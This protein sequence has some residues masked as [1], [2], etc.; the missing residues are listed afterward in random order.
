MLLK[1]LKLR[2]FLSQCAFDAITRALFLSEEEDALVQLLCDDLEF[3]EVR[4]KFLQGEYCDVDED[5]DDN[6]T[7]NQK[8]AARE[9][10][11]TSK[12][13]QL[14][15]LSA[16]I[17][18][19]QLIEKFPS[20]KSHLAKDA[21]IVH[22]QHFEN[23]AVK[24]QTGQEDRLLRAEKRAVE[25]FLVVEEAPVAEPEEEKEDFALQMARLEQEAKATHAKKSAYRSLAHIAPT[26]V[27]VERLFSR[28]KLIMTPHRR[29]MDPSTLEM[30]L[31]LR[32]NK[33]LWDPF[34]LDEVISAFAAEKQERKRARQEAE[35]R[36]REKTRCVRA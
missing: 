34:T 30:L 17:A 13:S 7:R 8:E 14:S 9:K 28:A 33:D 18:F 2:P 19:D 1:Y 22:N 16:R 36:E 25:S 11:K 24:I 3:V 21:P 27:V 15:L 20:M 23:A 6:E 35:A 26:S 5:E 4:S 10:K 12:R 29:K 32:Y 31:L